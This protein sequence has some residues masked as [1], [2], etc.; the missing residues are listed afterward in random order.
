MTLTVDTA[1]GPPLWGSR[2]DVANADPVEAEPLT[3]PR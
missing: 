1:P 3:S 2:G